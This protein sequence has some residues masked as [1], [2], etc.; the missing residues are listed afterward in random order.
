M[1]RDLGDVGDVFQACKQNQRVLQRPATLT[2][3]GVFAVLQQIAAEKGDGEAWGR[4]ATSS[5][6]SRQSPAIAC[7]LLTSWVP[8]VLED[9]G[10]PPTRPAPPAPPH[11]RF[12][13]AAAARRAGPAA[14][15]PRV[16][17][18]L[19]G[20]H[21]C[22][23]P[24]GGGQLA[25]RGAGAGARGGAAPGGSSRGQGAPRAARQHCKPACRSCGFTR[26]CS[27][28]PGSRVAYSAGIRIAQP[29]GTDAAPAARPQARLDMAAAAATA[30][31][32]V[33]PNLSLLADTMLAHPPQEWQQRCPLTPGE[34]LARGAMQVSHSADLGH[35][36]APSHLGW[37]CALHS[38]PLAGMPIKPM[39]ARISEGLG[40]ALEQLKGE[41]FLGGEAFDACLW[42]GWWG[43]EGGGGGGGPLTQAQSPE[44]RWAR[45]SSGAFGT[46]P[47]CPL[48]LS[49]EPS[50]PTPA[51]SG[52]PPQPSTSTTACAPRCTCYRAAA[53]ASSPATA[54][55][56]LHAGLT[57][58]RSSKR[59]RRVRLWL[60]AS[61]RCP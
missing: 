10:Q 21:A 23:Q 56:R 18:A 15:V 12:H 6:R 49:A 8:D 3:P 51:R 50:P 19:P 38:H 45:F 13:Q 17:A 4:K 16:R 7:L 25:L 40:D 43:A 41:P 24:A 58:R 1:Y 28:L 47:A 26:A 34:L 32:H 36:V 57:R 54:R 48:G 37:P 42:V 29:I 2:V 31:F 59:R 55:T 11:H 53:C 52:V 14:C 33:C 5:A 39:L 20:S 30:A 27:S 35:E 44:R 46:P 60:P 9:G 61:P 22:A